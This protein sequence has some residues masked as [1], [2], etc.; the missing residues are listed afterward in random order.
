LVD[1]DVEATRD[2]ILHF[3]RMDP[4]AWL[5]YSQA[6]RTTAERH[7]WPKAT[8]RLLELIGAD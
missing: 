4:E 3:V 6:A 8:E 1:G 2:G 5:T 7:T